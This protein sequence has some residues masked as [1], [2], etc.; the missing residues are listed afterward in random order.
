MWHFFLEHTREFCIISLRKK[1]DAGGCTRSNYLQKE[2]DVG[3]WDPCTGKQLAY[4]HIH[5]LTLAWGRRGEHSTHTHTAE[6]Q[7]AALNSECGNWTALLHCLRCGIY[8]THVPTIRYT[9]VWLSTA[10]TTPSTTS[11]LL[12]SAHYQHGWC[13][14]YQLLVLNGLMPYK[15]QH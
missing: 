8:P 7:P 12:R 3:P 10:P 1:C 2:K 15:L 14:F 5:T 4:Q 11:T 6:L 13:S 9:W